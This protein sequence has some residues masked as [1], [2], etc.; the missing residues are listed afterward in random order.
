VTLAGATGFQSVAALPLPTGKY[1][2]SA[3]FEAQV[4]GNLD[5]VPQNIDCRLVVGS[6]SDSAGVSFN[7]T[8]TSTIVA[9]S[10]SHAFTSPGQASIS[11]DTGGRNGFSVRRTRVTAVQVGTLRKV[12][13]A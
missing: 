8:D 11:C 4:T 1:V 7:N 10:T 12:T 5:S 13:M 2:V 3:T 6:D 9:L